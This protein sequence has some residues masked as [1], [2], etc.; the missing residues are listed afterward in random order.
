MKLLIFGGTRF[1]G[2]HLVTAA[3][4][5]GHEL[6]LFNRGQSNA[7]LFTS[8]EQVH[9]NRDGGLAALAPMPARKWDA[10][11]DL[12]GFVPR[13]V[14]ASVE[15]LRERVDRY[16]FISSVSVYGEPPATMALSLSPGID[17]DSPVATLPD[18]DTEEV[19]AYYGALKAA[20]EAVVKGAFGKRALIVRPGLIVGPYDPTGRFTYWPHP[21]S[22]RSHAAGT[23]HRRA[24]SRE[25]ARGVVG[26]RSGRHV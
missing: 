9:G 10:V 19:M 2:R 6:T 26:E 17:E 16:V 23:V 22:W 3:F 25:L 5:R 12:C 13:V 7:A 1:L 24:R 14:R 11:V 18:A 4:A 15:L 21:R 8:L 20:C